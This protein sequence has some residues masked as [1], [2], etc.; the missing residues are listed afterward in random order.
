MTPSTRHPSPP[1]GIGAHQNTHASQRVDYSMYD[2]KEGSDMLESPSTIRQGQGPG[3][4]PEQF[5]YS[6]LGLAATLKMDDMHGQSSRP[7]ILANR[8]RVKTRD[9]HAFSSTTDLPLSLTEQK[10]SERGM[11]SNDSNVFA[12]SWGVAMSSMNVGNEETMR[13]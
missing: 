12:H 2:S 13:K 4:G 10:P 11:Q 1:G 8:D 7:S 3:S 9:T 6:R 5:N